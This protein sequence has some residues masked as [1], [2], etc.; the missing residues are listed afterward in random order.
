MI[1][2]NS[3]RKLLVDEMGLPL[4]IT[5]AKELMALIEQHCANAPTTIFGHYTA[6]IRKV[7]PEWERQFDKTEEDFK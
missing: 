7:A 2:W 3:E 6:L 5:E 4:S 1:Q